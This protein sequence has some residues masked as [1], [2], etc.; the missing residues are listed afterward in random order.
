MKRPGSIDPTALA[1]GTWVKLARAAESVGSRIHRHLAAYSLTSSQFGVLEALQHLG[2]MSQKTL[3]RKILKSTGNI[4]HVLDNMERQGLV[5]RKPDPA[6]RRALQVHLTR[7]GKRLI[8]RLFPRHSEIITQEM[9]V[10]SGT[11][12]QEL[13][14]LCRKLGLQNMNGKGSMPSGRRRS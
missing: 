1:L 9:S 7:S 3:S 14:R 8:A 10:L 5:I 6:D 4:T 2:P 11:E 13:G 12:Q